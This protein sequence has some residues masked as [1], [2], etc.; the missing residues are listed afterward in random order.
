MYCRTDHPWIL[1]N[2]DFV[3]AS[4]EG[5]EYG[6]WENEEYSIMYG[7]C[8]LRLTIFRVRM[9]KKSKSYHNYIRYIGKKGK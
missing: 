7:F 4:G 9:K 6:S 3:L 1:N 5:L 2:L 8:L